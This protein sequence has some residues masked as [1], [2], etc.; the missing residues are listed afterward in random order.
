MQDVEDKIAEEEGSRCSID[1][2]SLQIKMSEFSIS[3]YK[4]TP[5]SNNQYVN[6][7]SKQPQL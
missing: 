6:S 1:N 5:F 3:A 7:V 4:L 2:H